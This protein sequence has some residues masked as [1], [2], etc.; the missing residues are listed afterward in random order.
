MIKYRDNGT[1]TVKQTRDGF[2]K[3]TLWTFTHATHQTK[4]M[5]L[6]AKV[7][8]PL[9]YVYFSIYRL[10]LQSLKHSE[11]KN[12]PPVTPPEM[13]FAKQINELTEAPSHSHRR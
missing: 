8:A 4:C 7:D 1:V 6:H 12:G 10:R 3:Q 11:S 2:R 9:S 13:L 5:S